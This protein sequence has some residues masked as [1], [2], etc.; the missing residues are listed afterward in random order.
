MPSAAV[1]MTVD[2]F[3]HVPDEPVPARR[4]RISNNPLGRN[5]AGTARG[6][7]VNDLL[8]SYLRAMN[9]RSCFA[10]ADALRAAELMV[11][12]E[13]VRA[14]LL[15]GEGDASAVVRLENLAARAVRKLGLDQQQAKPRRTFAQYAREKAARKAGQSGS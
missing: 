6:R 5:N 13:E 10:Q 4:S 3:G 2:L 14:K 15:A 1:T 12:A 7:R 9:N 11:A 8:R